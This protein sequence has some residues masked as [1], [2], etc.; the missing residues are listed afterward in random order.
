MVPSQLAALRLTHYARAALILL[1]LAAFATEHLVHYPMAV[2]TLWGAVDFVRSRPR[3]RQGGW[4]LGL[5]ALLWLPQLASLPDAANRT[6]SLETTLAYVHFLPVAYFVWRA[7]ST[8]RVYRLVTLGAA[9]LLGFVILDAFAQ[10]IWR[11][12]LFGYPPRG[13]SLTGVFHPKQRL[14]VCLA[15]FAPLLIDVVWRGCRRWP[16]LWL[17]YLPSAIVLAMSLKRVA[18]MML[19]VGVCGYALTRWRRSAAGRAG[20]AWRGALVVSVAGVLVMQLPAFDTR[21]AQTRDIVSKDFDAMDAASAYRLSLWRTAADIARE[22]WVNGIG[23]RGFRHAYAAHAPA[24][25]FWLARNGTGQTHPHLFALEVAAETGVIGLAAYA[26]FYLALVR[27]WWR[28]GRP[29]PVWLLASLVATLPLNAHHA[30]YGSYW[31]SLYWL[32]L[33]IGLAETRPAR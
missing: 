16:W 20:L 27:L 14:G 8:R 18:W 30:F 25:D 22:H 15:V 17:V 32:V 33:A 11:V 3:E 1:T 9:C 7:A 10:L 21:V 2:M 26:A 12:D 13:G 23:P 6:H 5:F 29:L 4:V 19:A 28:A 24:D 31:A